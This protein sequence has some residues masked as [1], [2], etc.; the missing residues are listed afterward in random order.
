MALLPTVPTSFVPHIA[1]AERRNARPDIGS[2]FGFLA[3][4]LLVI[5]LVL[6]AG[7]F[8][9]SR[10]RI[11]TEIAK[12][13]DL[14]TA[15]SKIDPATVESFVQLRNRI[16]SSK[17]LLDNHVAFSAFFSTLESILPQTVRFKSL[18][19]AIDASNVARVQGSGISKNFN[20]LSVASAAFASDGRIKEVIFSKMIV[21]H[22]KSISFQFSA[23]L[24][25]KIVT[26][27]PNLV[28]QTGQG[29]A[30][31]TLSL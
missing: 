21:N 12:Q 10:I 8:F 15:Q 19:I 24:D 22:D 14:A 7:V 5:A 27:D 4:M 31:S 16:T 29:T 9:Y 17:T 30:S 28:I 2:A 20:A 25:P 26:Y 6:S 1:S 13:R 23:S 11:A 18:R 3:Y